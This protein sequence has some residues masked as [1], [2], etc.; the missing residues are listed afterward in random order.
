MFNKSLKELGVML[1]RREISS[2]ELTQTYLNRISQYNPSINAYIV[3][4]ADKTL[5][6][7]KAAD[8]LI[9]AGTAEPLTGIPFA[10]KDIFCAK[11]WVTTCG[12]KMLKDFTA[13]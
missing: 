1:A 4:D 13:P 8:A 9:A 6:Q 7:A 5:N 11:G 2:V 10:Q 12:S 3:L